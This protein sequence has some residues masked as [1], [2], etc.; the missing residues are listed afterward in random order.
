MGNGFPGFPA[1]IIQKILRAAISRF[2]KTI[3][4]LAFHD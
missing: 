3:F 4:V 1:F 2:Q